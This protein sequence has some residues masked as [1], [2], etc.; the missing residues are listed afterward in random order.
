MAIETPSPAQVE[1]LHER[2]LRQIGEAYDRALARLAPPLATPA[3][4]PPGPGAPEAAT[5]SARDALEALCAEIE[6][7][8]RALAELESGT[9]TADPPACREPGGPRPG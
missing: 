9:A 5:Q 1:A 7:I 3:L 2:Y 8:T 4:T 6:P